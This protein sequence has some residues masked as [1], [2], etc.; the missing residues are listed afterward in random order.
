[1]CIL[2]RFKV[3]L[4]YTWFWIVFAVIFAV[5]FALFVALAMGIPFGVMLMIF[6]TAALVFKEELIITELAPVSMLLGGI[7]LIFLAAACGLFAVKLG[8]LISK[9]FIGIKRRCDRLRDW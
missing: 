7:S 9:R 3:I 1:M 4:Y 2:A 8:F 6:G 5:M